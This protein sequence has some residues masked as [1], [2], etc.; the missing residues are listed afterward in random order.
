MQ[1]DRARTQWVLLFLGLFELCLCLGVF[2]SPPSLDGHNMVS[3]NL[4]CYGYF[5]VLLTLLVGC[6]HVFCVL[7]LLRFRVCDRV[8]SWVG[9]LLI[10]TASL[11]WLILVLYD[12]SLEHLEHLAGAGVFIAATGAYYCVMLRL[13]FHHDAAGSFA[14]DLLI[15]LVLLATLCLTLT[16]IA[17]YFTNTEKSWLVE[18]LA[19]L[20][21]LLGYL[22]FFLYHPFSAWEVIPPST[23]EAVNV[24]APSLCRPL[25]PFAPH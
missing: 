21:L 12:P 16:T 4:F 23:R 10:L 14:Y 25:L 13:A 5:R 20:G 11:G 24:E 9:V 15:V 8:W 6:Q 1:E 19:L 18:N 7:Y 3:T 2:V 17:I 22:V